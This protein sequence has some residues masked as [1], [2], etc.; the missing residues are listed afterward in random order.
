LF[1]RPASSPREDL[2]VDHS[3][4]TPPSPGVF[5]VSGNGHGSPPAPGTV[6]DCVVS[7]LR[8]GAL[9]PKIVVE[10]VESRMADASEDAVRNAIWKLID[11]GK[12]RPDTNL[13]LKLRR[14]AID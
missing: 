13:R 2:A 5:A 1:D 9:A 11:G 8:D 10:R 3:H 7:V 4:L 12:I 14:H 6:E